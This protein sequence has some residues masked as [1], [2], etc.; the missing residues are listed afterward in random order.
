LDGDDEYPF[1]SNISLF[2]SF[3]STVNLNDRT[4]LLSNSTI[5]TVE[6]RIAEFN[7]IMTE[8]NVN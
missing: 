5:D 6:E 7:R 2:G 3:I 1:H 8:T 4:G